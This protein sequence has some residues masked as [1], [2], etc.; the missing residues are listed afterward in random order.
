MNESSPLS[1]PDKDSNLYKKTIKGGGWIFLGRLL[2]QLFGFVRW[3]VLAR[4]L[5]PYDFGILGIAALTIGILDTFTQTGFGI[6]LIQ[7]NVDIRPYL[8]TVWTVGIIRAAILFLFMCAIAPF[9]VILFDGK[10]EFSTEEIKKPYEIAQLLQKKDAIFVNL[11]SKLSSEAKT[12]LEGKHVLSEN[13]QKELLALEFTAI[14]KNETIYSP[15]NFS[16]VPIS[17]YATVL[18]QQKLEGQEL[19]RFNK[20]LIEEIFE[21]QTKRTILNKMQTTQI[22]WALA[23]IYFLASF[24]N[25]GVIYFQKDLDFHKEVM[26]NSLISIASILIT[27]ILAWII[28]NTWALVGGRAI[29]GIASLLL[30]YIMHPY[31]PHFEIHKERLKELWKFGKPMWLNSILDF[32]ATHGDD[33]IVL[34]MLGS[35]S[36]G[37][38]RYAYELSNSATTEVGNLIGK[39]SF[40]ALSKI[41]NQMEKLRNGYIKGTKLAAMV[42][43]PT[44]VV[45]CG[46]SDEVVRVLLGDKWAG[47]STTVAILSLLGLL[48]CIQAR[49]V[50][51]S[52]GHPEIPLKVAVMRLAPFFLIAYPLTKH[53]GLEGMA[54][55]IL[56]PTV[57]VIPYVFYKLKPLILIDW[58]FMLKM[59]YKPFLSASLMLLYFI[60]LQKLMVSMES[61]VLIGII[62]SGAAIYFF[63]LL[64]MSLIEKEMSYFIILQDIWKAVWK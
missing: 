37:F 61:L 40:S 31:R 3:V 62:L 19:A 28:R 20:R 48:K 58:L 12:A 38:Y 24:G 36:L 45:L 8:S 10:P 17:S 9:V 50:F 59:I 55:A 56:I 43:F 30:G 47:I 54:L 26:M 42:C 32:M 64:L 6:A 49:Q 16:E 4:L 27:I 44:T 5:S 34:K 2:Q 63:A 7:K 52:M 35:E 57:L 29:A 25:V 41:Q 13:Q 51:L 21:G 60:L 46:L 22:L 23:F 15:E 33:L 18:S 53:Y 14:C 1:S 39:V 11:S